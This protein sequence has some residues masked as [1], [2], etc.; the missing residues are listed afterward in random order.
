MPDMDPT[1]IAIRYLNRLN[2]LDGQSLA[3]VLNYRIACSGKLLDSEADD[4]PVVV[5]T[6]ADGASITLGPLGI[7]N[8]LL[9]SLGSGRV[10]AKY[11][12]HGEILGFDRRSNFQPAE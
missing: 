7:L 6:A 1:D 11:G 10:A 3:D 4:C 5:G 9:I 12:D 8:G 2:E